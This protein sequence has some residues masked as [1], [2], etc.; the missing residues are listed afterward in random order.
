MCTAYHTN[1]KQSVLENYAEKLLEKA[2]VNIKLNEKALCLSGGMHQRLI[3][4]RELAENPEEL[5]LFDPT[6]GLDA[7]ASERLYSR[8]QGLAKNGVKITIG[9]AV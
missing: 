8:L 5:Y 3:L 2:D 4:E 1:E 6:H 9:K 7:E